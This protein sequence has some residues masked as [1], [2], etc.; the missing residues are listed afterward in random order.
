MGCLFNYRWVSLGYILA[1]GRASHGFESDGAARVGDS[2]AE[3]CPHLCDGSIGR[4]GAI[5]A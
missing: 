1:T 4:A 2:L 5:L 3:L